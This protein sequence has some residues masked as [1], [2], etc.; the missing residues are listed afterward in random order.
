MRV[1]LLLVRRE[2]RTGWLD[3]PIVAGAIIFDFGPRE[4]AVYPDKE[5]G[6]AALRR[7][8][9]HAAFDQTGSQR[10]AGLLAAE[11]SCAVRVRRICSTTR[12]RSARSSKVS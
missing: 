9:V 8:A 4:S 2:Y 7:R 5:L 3:I 10:A 11:H 6:R 1:S 12:R